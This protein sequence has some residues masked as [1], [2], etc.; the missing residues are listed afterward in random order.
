LSQ[1]NRNSQASNAAVAVHD[2]GCLE[3]PAPVGLG[4]DVLERLLGHARVVLQRQR[5][6][7]VAMQPF[8]HVHLAHQPDEHGEPADALVAAG[9]PVELGADVEV[10][11]LDAHGH[12]QPPVKGGKKATSRAPSIGTSNVAVRWS[13]AAP[14]AAP[15]ANASACPLS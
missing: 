6:D 9:Q 13:T 5:I 3:R 8:A 10:A 2:Q 7:A 11:F 1:S 12:G 4:L 15:S 14:K